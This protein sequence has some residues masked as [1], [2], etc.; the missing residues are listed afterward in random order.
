MQ[1]RMFLLEMGKVHL[2][3]GIYKIGPID[4]SKHNAVEGGHCKHVVN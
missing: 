2:V 4:I 1:Q 3:L